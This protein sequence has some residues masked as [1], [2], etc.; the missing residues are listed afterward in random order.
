LHRTTPDKRDEPWMIQAQY[1][2]CNLTPYF[3]YDR[4]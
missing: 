1:G 3:R 2:S 4:I